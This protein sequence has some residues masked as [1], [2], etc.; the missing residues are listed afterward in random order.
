[1]GA[2][3]TGFEREG[4]DEPDGHEQS[5]W[6]KTR[7]LPVLCAVS[8]C[9]TLL[10]LETYCVCPNAIS[11][12]LRLTT[13]I[14]ERTITRALNEVKTAGSRPASSRRPGLQDISSAN[15]NKRFGRS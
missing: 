6:L 3:L 1:M 2:E 8:G 5:K 11:C 4:H 7:A 9:T 13:P 15:H 14:R 10:Q 12:G